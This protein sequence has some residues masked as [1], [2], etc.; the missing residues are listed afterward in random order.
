MR[1]QLVGE[2]LRGARAGALVWW[3]AQV[4]ACGL[5]LAAC[6]A[7]YESSCGVPGTVRACICP[8]LQGNLQGTQFCNSEGA[9]DDGRRSPEEVAA[10]GTTF[11]CNCDA[12][13]AITAPELGG[14]GT[15]PIGTGAGTGAI[16]GGDLGGGGSLGSGGSLGG[17]GALGTGAVMSGTGAAVG[18]GGA[19]PAPMAWGDCA[20]DVDCPSGDTCRLIMGGGIGGGNVCSAPCPNTDPSA[21][22]PAPGGAGN[23][24]CSRGSFAMDPLCTLG[25]AGGSCP[26]GMRC[27]VSGFTALCVW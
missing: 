5:G 20:G 16:G 24:T 10:G 13:V 26:A 14:S 27:T 23:V 1:E 18:T 6:E 17:G 9:W 2:G 22:P 15:P 25:C 12:P 21:C 8:G 19:A 11:V 3:L 7:V 4:A